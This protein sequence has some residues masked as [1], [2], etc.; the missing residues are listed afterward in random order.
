MDIKKL[1]LQ[2]VIIFGT[3]ER[4][5]MKTR[6]WVNGKREITRTIAYYLL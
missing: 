1:R 6:F 5:R 3:G 2:L 4:N